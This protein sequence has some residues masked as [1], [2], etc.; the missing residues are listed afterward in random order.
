V[1]L[2]IIIIGIVILFLMA[3]GL[4]SFF[5]NPDIPLALRIGVG[6]V[7]VGVLVMVVKFIKA[8]VTRSKV[9]ESKG[10]EK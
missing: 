3:F 8:K 1:Q 4:R 7:G 9:E 2:G 5:V 10:V 6:A